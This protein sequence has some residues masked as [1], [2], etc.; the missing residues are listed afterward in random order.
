MGHA[1]NESRELRANLVGEFE[2]AFAAALLA[3]DEVA[4]ETTI[5]EAM[6]A[7]LTSAEID[8]R[9]ITPALWLVGDL[10][11]RGEI[12]VAD[13]HLATEIALR[14]L[15]LQREAERVAL[16]R[17]RYRVMLATPA[18]EHHVVA[19]RMVSNLL[20][21]AGYWIVMLGADVPADALVASVVRHRPDVI[22][23][24]ATMPAV[25]VQMINSILQVRTADPTAQ[26]VIGG[27]GLTS[28]LNSQAGV[29]ICQRVSEV[30]EAV[31]A[32]VKR[33]ELN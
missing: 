16:A 24:S 15:A 28:Q 12:S 11:E 23:M 29:G 9:I 33:A 31:D 18:G 4:A 10:W 8:E 26:F 27:R 22:C 1:D 17:R 20:S 25:S 21:G 32:R 6:E 19:L 3:G 7:K 2:R 14:V 5:R 13:E 30:V